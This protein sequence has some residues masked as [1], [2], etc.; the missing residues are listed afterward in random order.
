M[1]IYRN[2]IP[3]RFHLRTALRCYLFDGLGLRP[4]SGFFR[5]SLQLEF[6]LRGDRCHVT[7]FGLDLEKVM[8]SEEKYEHRVKFLS[9]N[10]VHFGPAFNLD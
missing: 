10:R 7:E 1:G 8:T 2:R 4:V 6:R 3:T 9:Q 5:M